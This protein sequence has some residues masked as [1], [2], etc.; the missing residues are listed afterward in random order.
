MPDGL[1]VHDDPIYK[2]VRDSEEPL[3]DQLFDV[4]VAAEVQRVQNSDRLGDVAGGCAM[5]QQGIC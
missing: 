4:A 3:L 5:N 2:F 1:A